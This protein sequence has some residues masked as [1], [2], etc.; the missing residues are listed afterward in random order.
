MHNGACVKANYQC[1]GTPPRNAKKA[2]NNEE[3]GLISDTKISLVPENTS[4]KCEYVCNKGYIL[5]NNSC[6]RKY[7]LVTLPC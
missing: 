7:R 4:N 3:E 5:K 6:E 1:T 2:S